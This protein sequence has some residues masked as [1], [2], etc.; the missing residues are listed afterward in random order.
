MRCI[1][2]KFGRWLDMLYMLK[3]IGTYEEF[4]Q[5]PIPTSALDPQKTK[6]FLSQCVQKI[7]V[8]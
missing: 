8:L 7:K 3:Q 5:P 2:N 6:A 4:P 1:G